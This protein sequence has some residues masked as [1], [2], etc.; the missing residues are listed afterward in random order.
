MSRLADQ[1]PFIVR[2]AQKPTDLFN[3]GGVQSLP[4]LVGT[5]L[6]ALALATIAHLLTTSVRRRR[7]DFAILQAIG[8]TRGQ[9]RRVVAWQAAT[10]IAV[11]LVIGIPAG[12][13]CGRAVWLIFAHHLGILP[14]LSIPLGRFA[15]VAG[16]A[17]VLAVAI[18]ALPGESAARARPTQVLRSE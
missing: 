4:M 15:V 13:L 8:F 9:I 14:V 16:G 2:E 10:L 12:A 17:I 1:G 11:A 7:R 3:F 6:G 18:A 5:A